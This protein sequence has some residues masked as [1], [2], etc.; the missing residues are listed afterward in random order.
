SLPPIPAL[1][2]SHRKVCNH[3]YLLLNVES[4]PKETEKQAMDK[5]VAASGKLTLLDRMLPRL[6]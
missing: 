3:P 4:C 5:M 6:Q 1:P 2:P